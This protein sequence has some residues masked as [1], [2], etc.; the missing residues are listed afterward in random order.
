MFKVF[1]TCAFNDPLTSRSILRHLVTPLI[2]R[3]F[4]YYLGVNLSANDGKV[5]FF[6]KLSLLAASFL[7]LVYAPFD[8]RSI[9]ARAVRIDLLKHQLLD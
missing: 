9:C 8:R 1:V 7:L 4:P 3:H 2:G 6:V 5:Y